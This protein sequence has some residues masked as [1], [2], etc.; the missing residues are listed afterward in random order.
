MLA[1]SVVSL[2][3]GAS[4]IALSLLAYARF[5]S[6]G[7]RQLAAA[8]FAALLLL[9]VDLVKEYDQAAIANLAGLAPLHIILAAGGA[10][11]FGWSLLSLAFGFVRRRVPR[12]DLGIAIT[13]AVVLCLAGIW[14][15]ASFSVASGG[16]FLGVMTALQAGVLVVLGVSRRRIENAHLRRLVGAVLVAA[17]PLLAIVIVKDL[18]ATAGVIP[19]PYNALPMARVL[20]LIVME[21]LLL[22]FGMS[23]LFRPEP[24]PVCLLPD[25]F[26]VKYNISP[27]ECE[28][29]S[30]MVQGYSNRMIAEKLFIS[31]MTVKNHVYHIYQK[32][33]AGNKVR[34][35]N[36]I[37]SLK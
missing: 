16:T 2:A 27:R 15:E 36:L 21:G 14:R 20:Y 11:L 7:F 1:F 33:S 34:L 25:Q 37:N 22:G 6:I 28:I 30:M 35:I 12:R 17:P 19:A 8:I 24:A 32:T 4:A 23:Y 13:G 31:A 3:L 5:A 9:L 18:L 26:V 29:I 10:G